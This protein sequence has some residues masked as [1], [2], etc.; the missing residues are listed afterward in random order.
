M[1]L[2]G[3]TCMRSPGASLGAEIPEG[4]CTLTTAPGAR[5][6]WKAGDESRAKGKVWDPLTQLM[7]QRDSVELGRPIHAEQSQIR[8]VLQRY[9]NVLAH[10]TRGHHWLSAS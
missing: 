3:F 2:L 8:D 5:R 10:L 6:T 4:C 9:V 1:L 7:E